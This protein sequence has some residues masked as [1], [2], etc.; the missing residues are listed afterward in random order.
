MNIL[1]TINKISNFIKQ[2]KMNKDYK[3]EDI[4]E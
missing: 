4:F 1:K 3:T 2:T